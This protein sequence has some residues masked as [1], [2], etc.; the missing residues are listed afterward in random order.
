VRNTVTAVHSADALPADLP[1]GA[2]RR[3]SVAALADE[4]LRCQALGIRD[5]IL[6][7]VSPEGYSE[8]LL[9]FERTVGLQNLAAIHVN[10]SKRP[11]G[12]R[13]DRHEHIGR[14]AIGRKGF[15]NLMTD[16]RL[17]AIPKFLETPKDETLDHDR[18]NL[19]TLRRL[20]R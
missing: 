7:L 4:I 3:Q 9:A 6:Q 15:R 16:P 18:R 14:G 11:R 5:L 12:S 2:L 13:V 8:T 1:I 17:A 10:D 19:A 20:S